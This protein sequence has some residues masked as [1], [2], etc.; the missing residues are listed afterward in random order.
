LL[1]EAVR[2]DET[3]LGLSTIEIP[4]FPFEPDTEVQSPAA[5]SKTGDD[6]RLHGNSILVGHFVKGLAEGN[7]ILVLA[8]IWAV[9][10]RP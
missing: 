10:D 2:A 1:T 5:M 3:D 6:L 4:G 8:G 9:Y 7:G